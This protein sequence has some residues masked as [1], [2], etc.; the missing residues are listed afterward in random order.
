MKNKELIMRCR[1]QFGNCFLC[2][3]DDKE[4]NEQCKLF[5]NKNKAKPAGLWD[6]MNHFKED[7]LN[8]EVGE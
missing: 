8:Q 5:R 2:H 1:Y 7:W 4:L 6:F 3:V